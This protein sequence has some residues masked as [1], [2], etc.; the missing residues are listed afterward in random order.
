[1]MSFVQMNTFCHYVLL[2]TTCFSLMASCPDGEAFCLTQH[3]SAEMSGT[4]HRVH[5]HATSGNLHTHSIHKS[6]HVDLPEQCCRTSSNIPSDCTR[7]FVLPNNKTKTFRSPLTATFSPQI[8]VSC[9]K[10]LEKNFISEIFNSTNPTL[11]LLRTV[12][13]LA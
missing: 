3:D 12:I 4:S 1:M 13:L 10:L 5:A 2:A 8:T 6:H 7:I 11:A 9:F